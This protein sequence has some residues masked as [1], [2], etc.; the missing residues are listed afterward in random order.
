VEIARQKHSMKIPLSTQRAILTDEAKSNCDIATGVCRARLGSLFS[1]SVLA[2]SVQD[3]IQAEIDRNRAPFAAAIE[4]DI[5]AHPPKVDRHI[6]HCCRAVEGEFHKPGCDME[7]CP[8]CGRQLTS[9][10]CCYELLNIDH[11]ED[12]WACSNGL[13]VAQQAQWTEMLAKKG[14]VPYIAYP[15]ICCRCGALW[16]DMFGVPKPDWDKYVEKKYRDKMLCLDCYKAI[17]FMVDSAEACG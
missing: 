1:D 4:A 7:R 12:T 6:C 2:M 17:K 16:P 5:K 13:T 8:F 15:N 3:R 9:C 10:S 14:R 11:G